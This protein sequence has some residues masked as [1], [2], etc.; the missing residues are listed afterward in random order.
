[1]YSFRMQFKWINGFFYVQTLIINNVQGTANLQI[2]IL[3]NIYYKSR[4]SPIRAEKIGSRYKEPNR[5]RF[6]SHMRRKKGRESAEKLWL[7]SNLF[8]MWK[9]LPRKHLNQQYVPVANNSGHYLFA[10]GL[11]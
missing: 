7:F 5:G 4:T 3:H 8:I 6:N 1:M 11:L 2:I 9:E 10:I